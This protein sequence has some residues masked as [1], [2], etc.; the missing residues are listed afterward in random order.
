MVLLLR[1]ALL[2]AG[3]GGP[4]LPWL[5]VFGALAA[6]VVRELELLERPIGDQEC[7]SWLD[8]WRWLG[9][10]CGGCRLSRRGMV[11]VTKGRSSVVWLGWTCWK[12]VTWWLIRRA[13]SSDSSACRLLEK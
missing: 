2:A 9:S 1:G 6:L 10:G 4:R 12:V 7:L 13:R 11:K 8:C 5:P 3:W